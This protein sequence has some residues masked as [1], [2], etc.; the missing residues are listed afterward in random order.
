M[1]IY[2]LLTVTVKG[3]PTKVVVLVVGMFPS[4]V[5]VC[6]IEELSSA[7]TIYTNK[8]IIEN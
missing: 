7:T 3:L 1:F 6:V 2:N 8:F 5:V 4:D